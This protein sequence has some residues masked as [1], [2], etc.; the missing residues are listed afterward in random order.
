MIRFLIGAALAVSPLQALAQTYECTAVK[1]GSG[2]WVP[3]KIFVQIDRA[4]NTATAFD[5]FINQVHEH[6]IAVTMEQQSDTL[7]AL[8]WKLRNVD[9]TNERS[10]ILSHSLVL[11]TDTNTFSLRG[12]LSGYENHIKGSGTCQRMKK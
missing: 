12:R 11:D 8:S 2:G 1:R 5:T 7:V 3:D 9:I 4:A 10:S 6:P